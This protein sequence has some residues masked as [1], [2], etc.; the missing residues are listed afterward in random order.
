[1]SAPA[2]TEKKFGKASRQV[3]HHS[4]KAK[5]WYDVEDAPQPKKVSVLAT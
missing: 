1:M 3:P 5:K 4:Q 2:P